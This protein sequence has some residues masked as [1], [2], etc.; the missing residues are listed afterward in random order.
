[1]FVIE[2]TVSAIKSYMLE[3]LS[4]FYAERE[5]NYFF[6]KAVC[7]RLK[8]SDVDFLLASNQR[9]SESDLLYFRNIVKR[10]QNS[11]PFQYII[12]ETWFYDLLIKCDKRALI[13]RP[14]TEELVDLIIKDYC[15][16]LN[17]RVL[18]LC[19]GTGC[20]AIALAKNLQN[21]TVFGIELS[22]EAI[23]LAKKN[24][25]LNQVAI[26]FLNGNVLENLPLEVEPK[27]V[28][29]VVSNPPYIPLK[30]KEKMEKNV[31][32]FEPHM[33]LFV[34][35]RDPLMFYEKIADQANLVLKEKGQLYFEIHENFSN[36][37]K[38]LLESK[39][40]ENIEVLK[41]LQGKNR[42]IKARI[43]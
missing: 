2:N 9:L 29:I 3:R 22:Q 8:L 13:P 18:D 30:E 36:Q 17:L 25:L 27:S 10:L 33:A 31:L 20:I 42:M 19:S 11:E 21:A 39:G 14:E 34:S 1:M 37:T 41:D 28:D 40:F 15:N 16:I 24:A 5:I 26:T 43:K 23:D 7:Q 38:E 35:D 12:G 4:D 32:D 6:K